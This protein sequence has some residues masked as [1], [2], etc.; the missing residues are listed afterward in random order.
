MWEVAAGTIGIVIVLWAVVQTAGIALAVY[1]AK[2]EDA[3]FIS[4]NGAVDK[5]SMGKGTPDT[6]LREILEDRK[7]DEATRKRVVTAMIVYSDARIVE[8][9]GSLA[10]GKFN[11]S[12][13]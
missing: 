3:V 11:D 10:G 1:R 12:G 2:V 13:C 7:L 5:A 6:V 8:F 4:I 9:K